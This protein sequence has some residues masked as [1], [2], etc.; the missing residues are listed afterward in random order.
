MTRREAIDP[1][2]RRLAALLLGT[3]LAGALQAAPDPSPKLLLMASVLV[4]TTVTVDESLFVTHIRPFAASAMPRG[5]LPTAISARRARVVP[6]NTETELLSWF[7]IHTR[8][9]PPVRGSMAID[10]EANGAVGVAGRYT[11]WI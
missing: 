5:A 6:S 4:S 7:T 9:V 2:R 10:E 11:A 8:Y 3:P 1:A